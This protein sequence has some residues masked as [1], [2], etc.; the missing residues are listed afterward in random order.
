MR[1]LHL[2]VDD[3]PELKGNS[4]YKCSSCIHAKMRQRPFNTTQKRQSSIPHPATHEP[5]FPGQQFHIDYGFMK[6]TGFGTQDKDGRTITS[7]D[8]YRSYCIIVDRKTRYTWI[9]L[10]RTKIPPLQI[11]ATFLQKHGTQETAHRIIRTDQGGELWASQDFRK[12]AL[13]AG[14]LLEP[15]GSGA[16][17]QNGLAE[18]PNQTFGQM[19]RCL[20]HSSGLGII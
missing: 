8:G 9:F 7:I 3:V 14:Y 17:F 19:V 11:M 15:T 16:P 4:F 18:R 6:G 20:L 12:L 5:H 13:D 1:T 2:H 10:T